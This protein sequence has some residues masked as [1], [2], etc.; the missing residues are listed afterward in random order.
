MTVTEILARSSNVGAVMLALNLGKQ[1]LGWWIQRFGFGQRLGI[2]FPGESPGIVVPPKRWTGSTIG[3]VPIGQGIAV[4]PLQMAS[5]YAAIANG[6]VW[7]QPHFAERVGD[8]SLPA[9]D[10]R[11]IVARST[12]RQ[13]VDMMRDVVAGG[14]GTEAEVAHYTV[15][16]KTGTAAKPDETGGYSDTAYVAS[17]VGIVPAQK[18]RL[19]ILVAVDEPQG[20]IYGGTVAAPAFA[21]IAEFALQY[22]DVPPDVENDG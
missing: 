22:L 19:A 11:R 6:G 3:N 16:G 14:T 7:I 5:V 15:A 17:F 20:D 8:E 1:R 12:A 4:T 9:P 10:R 18:P 2:D 21:T 13:V